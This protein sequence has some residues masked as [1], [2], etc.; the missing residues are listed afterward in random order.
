ME[1][2]PARAGAEIEN[3]LAGLRRAEA[4]DELGR[5]VLDPDQTVPEGGRLPEAGGGG[6]ED[7]AVLGESGRFGGDSLCRER[8][9]GLLSRCFQAIHADGERR[10][11]VVRPA[12]GDRFVDAVPVEPA[13][14]KP[15]GVGVEDGDG[16]AWI[17]CHLRPGDLLLLSEYV[18][19]DGVHQ[20][21]GGGAALLATATASFT[22]A[23]AGIRSVKK[24][25]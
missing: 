13:L 6:G 4:G 12:D 21:R 20:P 8:G 25:W 18:S 2:F 24:S 17:L 10:N 19:E 23:K 22:A 9:D 3:P 15:A 1:G 16:F 7:D 5:L 14:D 11:C